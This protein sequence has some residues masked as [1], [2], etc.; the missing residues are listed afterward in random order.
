M[1]IAKK[2]KLLAVGLLTLLAF[3]LLAQGDRASDMKYQWKGK[4]NVTFTRCL[5]M[6][7][8]PDCLTHQDRKEAAKRVRVRAGSGV[9]GPP[10]QEKP[11]TNKP[12]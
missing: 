9:S 11:S 7:R 1:N 3:P 12:E 10:G 2:P 8:G 5:G 6:A 4:G